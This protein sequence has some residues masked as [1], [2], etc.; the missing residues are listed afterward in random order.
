MVAEHAKP[1]GPTRIIE[2]RD[3]KEYC[4]WEGVLGKESH[5]REIQEFNIIYKVKNE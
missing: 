4:K 2:P 3:P 5:I 1:N